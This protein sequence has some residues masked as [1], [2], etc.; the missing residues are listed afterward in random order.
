MNIVRVTPLFGTKMQSQNKF[1]FATQIHCL[2]DI[3]N[4]KGRN[5][6]PLQKESWTTTWTW[7]NPDCNWDTFLGLNQPPIFYSVK[8]SLCLEAAERQQWPR[9]YSMGRPYAKAKLVTVARCFECWAGF[10]LDYAIYCYCYVAACTQ[11]WWRVVVSGT[12]PWVVYKHK[13]ERWG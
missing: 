8:A 2:L 5:I 6:K 7:M 1:H 3:F 11:E 12:E 13:G 9:L 4:G 10:Q